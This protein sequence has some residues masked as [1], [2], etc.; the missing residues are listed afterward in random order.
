M[1]S[2]IIE[3]DYIHACDNWN[4]KKCC[5]EIKVKI[6]SFTERCH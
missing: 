4:L 5:M 3:H 6:T 1:R 2:Q